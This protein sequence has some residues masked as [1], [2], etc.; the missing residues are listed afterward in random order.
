[1][2]TGY[3]LYCGEFRSS[4]KDKNPDITNN[5][6]IER[7]LGEMWRALPD[8]EKTPWLAKGIAPIRGSKNGSKNTEPCPYF[9]DQFNAEWLEKYGYTA[10]MT[11]DEVMKRGLVESVATKDEKSTFHKTQSALG[12]LSTFKDL[13]G[14]ITEARGVKA[15]LKQELG[16]T[17]TH[18][19]HLLKTVG[20]F[21]QTVPSTAVK[22][23]QKRVREAHEEFVANAQTQFGTHVFPREWT[24]ADACR[25]AKKPR[26]SKSKSTPKK[27]DAEKLEGLQGTLVF[28]EKGLD[29]CPSLSVNIRSTKRTIQRLEAKMKLLAEEDSSSSSSSSS[30]EGDGDGDE[31]DDSEAEAEAEAE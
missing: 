4:V 3:N 22:K 13:V 11:R 12:G 20:T 17:V 31:G 23:P 6:G 8:A 16:D 27:T 1:M 26:K 18:V 21:Q 28:L 7:I 2:P 30:S 14:K 10:D 9:A 24:T 29:Q 15:T 19:E 25:F 5:R